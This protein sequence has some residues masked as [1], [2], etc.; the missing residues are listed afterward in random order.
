MW[1]VDHMP[2]IEAQFVVMARAPES[3]KAL[4]ERV[5]G[6]CLPVSYRASDTEPGIGMGADFPQVGAKDYF[7]LY[8]KRQM[9]LPDGVE[10]VQVI[11]TPKHGSVEPYKRPWDEFMG[12]RYV[13]NPGYEG[14]DRVEYRV[15][16]DGQPVRL[17][18]FIHVTKK[19]LDAV[20]S[21]DIC[22][23]NP[24]K[25]SLPDSSLDPAIQEPTPAC[26]TR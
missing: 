5:M 19:N 10:D 17:V 18:Y 21:H 8:E 15:N 11:Y 6:I 25:I 14:Q 26:P 7:G 1:V 20:P 12:W 9:P 22:K 24:W 2:T 4:K 3:G 23:Q 16:V 13:P